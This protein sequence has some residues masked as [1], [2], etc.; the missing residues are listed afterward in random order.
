[1]THTKN[2]IPVLLAV[3]LLALIILTCCGGDNTRS[4]DVM[5][6][7]A[8]VTERKNFDDLSLT[9]YYIDPLILTRAPLSVDRLINFRSVKIIIINGND[10][11]EQI[12]LFKQINKD[13]LIPADDISLIDARFYYVFESAKDGKLFEVAMWGEDYS[14][15]VNEQEVRENDIFYNVIIPFL[16]EDAKTVLEAYLGR[17]LT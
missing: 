6:S 4:K 12:S 10:M 17:E 13:D 1:M 15:F 7:L 5:N 14:I 2:I 8:K 16:S 3:T 11:K 9:I